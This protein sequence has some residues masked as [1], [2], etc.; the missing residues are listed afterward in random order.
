M[1]SLLE[2]KNLSHTFSNGTEAIKDINISFEKSKFIVIGGA[3]GS[4]KTVL[5]RHFNGLLKPTTGRVLLEGEDI[6]K[7]IIKTRTKIGLVFQEPDTQFV[8]QTVKE[9]IAFGPENLQLSESIINQRVTA[10]MEPVGLSSLA[11]RRPYELSGGEKRKL[12]IAGVLAMHPEII[13]F[14]EPFTGLDYFGVTQVLKALVNLHELKKTIIVITHDLEKV[15]AHA[16]RLI[17]LEKGQIVLDGIPEE[18]IQEVEKYGIR[19]PHGIDRDVK[20][21]TW[22]K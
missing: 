22:L 16:D 7:D 6:F 21:M 14:D 10:S 20:T 5:I 3:N 15:I 18:V 1:S 2:I 13:I 11:E 4:G 12:A 9:D 8:G 17:V 19:I